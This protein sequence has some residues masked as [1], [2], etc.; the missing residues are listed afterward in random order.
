MQ[1]PSVPLDVSEME[2]IMTELC[3]TKCKE[4]IGNKGWY[5]IFSRE[6]P[7]NKKEL[8]DVLIGSIFCVPCYKSIMGVQK[9]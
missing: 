3:C 6:W 2:K 5:R 1:V 9:G 7:W 4:E 8:L